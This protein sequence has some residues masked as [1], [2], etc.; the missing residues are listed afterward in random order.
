MKPTEI[1]DNLNKKV[2]YNSE[3]LHIDG[4]FILSGAVF[5]KDEKGRF[6]YQAELQTMN[7]VPL[8]RLAFPPFA[9]KGGGVRR[10]KGLGKSPGRTK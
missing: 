1:K 5:R 9:L 2:H 6:Y 4:D 8:F 3:S 7:G 10:G